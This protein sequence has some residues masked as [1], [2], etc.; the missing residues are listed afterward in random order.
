MRRHFLAYYDALRKRLKYRLGSED[1]ANDVLH[2]TY[3]RIEQH[4]DELKVRNPQAYLY[5]A[6]LNVAYDQHA[7]AP[8][9]LS[10]DEIDE[11]LLLEDE[12]QDPARI[13]DARNEVKELQKVLHKLPWRQHEIL[14]AARLEGV[15]HRDIA[16]RFHIST[17]MVEKELKAALA[18]CARH[19][20][21]NVIQQFGPGAEK[22]SK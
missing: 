16:Q 3:L 12:T 18:A 5:R 7:N 8:R 14:I 15:S 2:E 21:R 1:L 4:D 10:V 19:M 22:T 6:A 20:K 13:V 9:L 17:R 11:L